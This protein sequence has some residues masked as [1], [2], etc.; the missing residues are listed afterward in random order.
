MVDS[1]LRFAEELLNP[2]ALSRSGWSGSS[3]NTL[4]CI[5]CA[6]RSFRNYVL[7]I[8]ATPVTTDRLGEWAGVVS[9]DFYYHV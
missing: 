4:K 6:L 8:G 3:W 5:Y 1:L 9:M 2:V 7:P